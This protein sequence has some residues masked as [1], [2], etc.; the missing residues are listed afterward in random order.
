[1]VAVG[2]GDVSVAV[3]AQQ[4]DG[5]PAQRGHHAGR[6]PGSEQRFVL[7]IGDVADPVELVLYLPVPADPDGLES[8]QLAVDP[9]VGV[10]SEKLASGLAGPVSVADLLSRGRLIQFAA[11]SGIRKHVDAAVR[12][13]GLEVSSPFELNQVSDTL[14]FAALGLGV[15]IVPRTL[16]VTAAQPAEA[17]Q[18]YV[19]L[20]LTDPLAVHPVTVIFETTQFTISNCLL[21]GHVLSRQP[22]G[23]L[24]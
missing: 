15:T 12:R 13:A 16:T 18:P 23:R 9:L 6:V 20:G 4:A 1:V 14:V 10:A 17:G 11:G 21:P 5:Q 8:R 24:V 19:V 7:L 22:R 3:Q 2:R